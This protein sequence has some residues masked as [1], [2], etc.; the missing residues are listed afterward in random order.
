MLYGLSRISAVLMAVYFVLKAADLVVRNQLGSV[1]SFTM[2]G[3][4]FLL[5]MAL[6]TVVPIVICLL[7]FG[8]T[9]GGLLTFGISGMCGVVLTRF[10]VVFTGM[11]Q[12][13]G[14]NYFPSFLE[15]ATTVGLFCLAFLAY[16][17]I[18]ENFPFFYG[19]AGDADNAPVAES[20]E[21]GFNQA[22]L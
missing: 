3:N 14:G 1:F 18:T 10:N 21:S 2:E 7:P 12:H 17:Y 9:K 6:L 20:A 4:M 11:A 8:K 13:L 19:V 15:I 16:L 5:E 22:V